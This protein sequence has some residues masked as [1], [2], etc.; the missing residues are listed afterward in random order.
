MQ[1]RGSYLYK[2]QV[3]VCVGTAWAATDLKSTICSK[4]GRVR[5]QIFCLEGH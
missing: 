4:A 2:L 5:P 3:G 1:I